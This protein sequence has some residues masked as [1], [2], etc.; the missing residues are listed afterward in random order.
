MGLSFEPRLR[1]LKQTRIIKIERT[2]S[3]PIVQNVPIG[4]FMQAAIAVRRVLSRGIFMLGGL[5]NPVKRNQ[6]NVRLAHQ[7]LS[8]ILDAMVCKD[9]LTMD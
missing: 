6:G 5:I 2:V 8:Q 9:Q 4:T 3:G 1:F 7:I